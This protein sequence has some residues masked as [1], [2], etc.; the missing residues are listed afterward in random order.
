MKSMWF[1]VVVAA[2]FQSCGPRKSGGGTEGQGL[3]REEKPAGGI[4]WSYPSP[5]ERMHEIPMRVVTYVVPSYLEDLD[6]AE[7]AVFYFGK[8]QGGTVDDN[9]NRWGSQ[10]EGVGQANKASMESGGMKITIVR[11]SGTYLA[12]AGPMMESQGKK[13]TYKL[14]GSIVEAPEG[15]VFFKL[16]GP[17]SLIEKSEENF[18]GMMESIAKQ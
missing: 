4:V 15:L 3:V 17:A 10:F 11:I 7:C 13:S 5:W 18:Q 2:V 12:P 9:I 8:D 6:A 1:I 14:L 16:T